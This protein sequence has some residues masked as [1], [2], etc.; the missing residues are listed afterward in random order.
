MP[1]IRRE[2]VI[3][4]IVFI[5]LI[6]S[7]VAWTQA[8][9]TPPSWD[10][11][12]HLRTSYDFYRPLS[13]GQFV[14]FFDE[15]F[16]APHAYG[17][18]FHWI[19]AG[20]FLVA[21]VSRLTGIAANF[22]GLAVLLFSVNWIGDRLH[23]PFPMARSASSV[24]RPG[25]IAALLAVCYHFPAWLIHEAFLDYLLT[26]MVALAFALLMRADEFH[27]RSDAI[28]FGVVAGLG[29]LAKQTFLFFFILP[30][31]ALWCRALIRRDR[32]AI[33]NLAL[34]ATVAVFIA[35][36]WYVPHLNDVIGI[37]RVN[38][39]NAAVEH[40]APVFSFRF[41][42]YYWGVLGGLQIQLLFGILF[43]FGVAYS[44]RRRFR[45]DWMLYL[46]ILSGILSF[47]LIANKDTRYTVPILP[48]VALLSVSW[49]NGVRP[50]RR[51]P[52]AALIAL[53]AFV[54]FFNAQWPS[55]KMDF[56]LS[57]MDTPLYFL[58]GNVFRFDHHPMSE[59]WSVPESVASASGRLAVVPNLW[60][61]NPSNVGL[62]ARIYAPQV[63]VVW[64]SDEFAGDRL[65]QC[66]YVLARAHLESSE[67]VAPLERTVE[68]YLREHSDRFIPVATFALPH[69]QEAVLYRR[70]SLS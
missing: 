14:E 8:N 19:T 4:G 42:A 44:V 21:G 48:A 34:S 45:K 35:S 24:F 18:L 26:A 37:Y 57:A 60:Q 62:H 65:E 54:S 29:M 49:L 20:I 55:P 43:L 2:H 1:A 50:S 69:A 31:I 15:L 32:Q 61:L 11:A 40:E 33:A 68:G 70:I 66:E 30:G 16:R 63:K 7:T 58:S 36:I 52:A 10:P 13:H 64:F 12:D 5:V 47:T 38:V 6:F 27:V 59:D 46:W 3:S 23:P 56:H 22:L 9:R 39:V 17:P 51:L 28:L 41:L 25:A 53:L 67:T